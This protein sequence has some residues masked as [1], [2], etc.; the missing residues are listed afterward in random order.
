MESDPL[1]GAALPPIVTLAA[2]PS[3]PAQSRLWLT[4]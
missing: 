2:Y 4:A 1:V 3:V